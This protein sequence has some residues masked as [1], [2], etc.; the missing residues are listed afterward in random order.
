[1]KGPWRIEYRDAGRWLPRAYA[2]TAE[3]AFR[4]FRFSVAKWPTD[5]WR[6][7]LGDGTR[8]VE[9][10]PGETRGNA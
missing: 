6:I 1:M 4:M 2:R 5:D 3:A 8:I 9:I 7:A 10:Q